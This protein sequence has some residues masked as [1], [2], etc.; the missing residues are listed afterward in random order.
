MI[1]LKPVGLDSRRVIVS[2][3]RWRH[4]IIAGG[5]NWRYP[6]AVLSLSKAWRSSLP[7]CLWVI[8]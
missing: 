3:A 1:L 5:C 6:L 8:A 2:F 4:L 7:I